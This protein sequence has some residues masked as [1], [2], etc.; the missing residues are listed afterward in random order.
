VKSFTKHTGAVTNFIKAA[1]EVK[2][3]NGGKALKVL[4]FD[5]TDSSSR[6]L[7]QGDSTIAMHFNNMAIIMHKLRKYT[8]ASSYMLNAI[9]ANDDA[10]GQLPRIDSNM[11]GVPLTT[12]SLSKKTEMLRN[13]GIIKLFNGQNKEGNL[14]ETHRTW[15]KYNFKN[16]N[17]LDEKFLFQ[18]IGQ[19]FVCY[20]YSTRIRLI[21]C[22]PHILYG[23]VFS[24]YHGIFAG[25]RAPESGVAHKTIS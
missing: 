17:M 5:P 16:H 12:L 14:L 13:F 8:L 24:R 18:K 21:V 2:R 22:V 19:F 23:I 10:L 6:I 20:F 11:N 9:H 3:N 7:H 25:L 4:N 15:T 1:F